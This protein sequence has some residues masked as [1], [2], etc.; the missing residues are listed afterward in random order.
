MTDPVGNVT[1]FD[2]T[3]TLGDGSANASAGSPQMPNLFSGEAIRPPWMVAGVDYAVG[4]PAGT[5]LTDWQ[6]LS[7]PGISRVNYGGQW[8]VRVDNTNGAVISGVDFSLHGGA[9]LM[10]VNSP[11][12]VVT[13]SKFSS[14][15]GIGIQTDANSPGLTVTHSILDGGGANGSSSLIQILAGGNVTLQYDVFENFPQHVIEMNSNG[16]DA[17]LVYEYNLI[18]NGG[19]QPGAHLNVLQIGGWGTINTL[20]E[21]NTV[22]QQPQAAGAGEGFQFY[23]T[24]GDTLVSPTFAYNTMISTGTNSMSYLLHGSSG[25]QFPTSV[26]GTASVHDNYFDPRGTYSGGDAGVLYPG[27]FSGW[28]IY[29]NYNMATGTLLAGQGASG[30]TSPPPVTPTG[31][32]VPTVPTVPVT[33]TPP[34]TSLSN[35][36]FP[37]QTTNFTASF[38]T[39]PSQSGADIA[40]GLAPTS[41]AAFTDLAA[42]VR[43]NNNNTIDVRNGSGYGADV[44]VPYSAGTN[45]HFRMVVNLSTDT[46]SVFVT[47]QGGS[48]IALATNYA[49]RTEQATDTSLSDLGVL[50]TSGSAP[51]LNFSIVSSAPQPSING[52]SPDSGVVGDGIT[53]ASVL[54]LTGKATANSTVNVY[55]GTTLLG[56]AV[57]NGSGAWS[58]STG[59]LANGTHKFT[60]TDSVASGTT[61]VA[62]SA[63]SV[64][65]D[66]HVPSAPIIS[67]FSTDSGVVGDHI[68]NDKTLTLN[69]NAEANST[70]KVY[71]GTTLLGSV[72][73]NSNGLWSFTTGALA[74]V[75]HSFTATAT[76]AAGN[77]SPR[78]SALSVTTDTTAPNAPVIASD[79]IVN[80]D[81]VL[82]TGTAEA[83]SKVTVLD[84]A[85]L[86]GTTAA[87]STG[88]W[89][90]TTKP[91]SDGAHGFTATATDVAGNTSLASQVLDPI[92]GG[93]V[94]EVTGLDEPDAGWR[95]ILS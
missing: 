2:P 34:P 82:L 84:G 54:T 11:N 91:L 43:F 26:T 49:F 39:T 36:S 44:S 85:T 61:S 41:A 92:I 75:P 52:F 63:L 94:I 48:E 17:N 9:D 81:Q 50:S 22:Y 88:A 76:D 51:I 89:S 46:Y 1:N 6:N 10:F 27:S 59:T 71:D 45:Y 70:V 42:I 74:D 15:S 57:A 32:T 93:T 60:A 53:N 33:V 21:Y 38:D 8:F 58:Y 68:T 23:G 40:I 29:G 47:P 67:S 90:Y 55:D 79:A 24:T 18:T 72:T 69:G 78:S 31:P 56:T 86:L 4:V 73:A 3:V 19:M 14:T 87:D 7:G 35:F 16:N 25:T 66:T 20:V 65:V 83:N 95:S 12:G 64:T 28:T 5:A 37:T 77:T 62:S 80:T 30:P 13:N